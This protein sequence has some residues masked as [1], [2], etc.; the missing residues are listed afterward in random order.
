MARRRW[1]A[2]LV[3]ALVAGGTGLWACGGSD[4]DRDNKVCQRCDDF[5]NPGCFNEC[6]ELCVAN[7]P[8]CETRCTAQ[9]DVCRRDLVCGECRDGCTGTI[10]RCA[11]QNETVECDDGV[12]GGLPPDVSE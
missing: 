3:V 5:V 12:F 10:L 11:P 2:I 4:G 1:L 6:R 7:D 9:C 8:N